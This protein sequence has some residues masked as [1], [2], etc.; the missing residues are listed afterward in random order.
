MSPTV[1]DEMSL[2]RGYT[3][4]F[5]NGSTGRAARLALRIYISGPMTGFRDL[6]FPVFN[7]AA[8]A[9]RANGMDVVNPAEENPDK[10]STWNAC[11]RSDIKRLCD[12]NAVAMLPGWRNNKGALLERH[13]A[14]QLGMQILSLSEWLQACRR[15]GSLRQNA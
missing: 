14:R 12:C 9:L 11:L 15:A 8:E 1:D 6:N 10:G 4:T 7:A 5:Q 2:A 13:I 3:E